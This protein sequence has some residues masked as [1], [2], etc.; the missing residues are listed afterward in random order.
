[1]HEIL[2][3]MHHMTSHCYGDPS[4]RHMGDPDVAHLP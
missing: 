3:H 1:M 2:D 4:D